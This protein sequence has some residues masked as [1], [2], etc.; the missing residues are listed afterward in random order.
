MRVRRDL[1]ASLARRFGDLAV[2]QK[3]RADG[4]ALVPHTPVGGIPIGLVKCN[5]ENS[6]D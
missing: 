6:A 3:E 2:Q 5:G 1:N 4:E